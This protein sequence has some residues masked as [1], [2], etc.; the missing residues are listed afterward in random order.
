VLGELQS[1]S[2]VASGWW[3]RSFFVRFWYAFKASLKISW[4]L[5]DEEVVAVMI[6]WGLDIMAAG[7]RIFDRPQPRG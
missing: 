6:G 2:S 3:R 7:V 1:S 5:D 4:N